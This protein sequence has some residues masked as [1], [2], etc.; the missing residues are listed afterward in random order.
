MLGEGLAFGVDGEGCCEGKSGDDRFPVAM[1]P[2]QG[3]ARRVIEKGYGPV[4]ARGRQG[5]VQDFGCVANGGNGAGCPGDG[6]LGCEAT[7]H[8][9]LVGCALVVEHFWGCREGGWGGVVR[10]GIAGSTSAHPR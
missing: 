2:V 5:A 6:R 8:G 7:G 9:L 3:G 10:S 4:M 1:G